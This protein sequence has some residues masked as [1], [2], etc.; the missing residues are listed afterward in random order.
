MKTHKFGPKRP[1]LSIFRLK[2]EKANF[3]FEISTL[4]F[5][6]LRNFKKKQKWLNWGPKM[7]YLGNFLVRT[8]K[9]Y[10]DIWNQHPRTC[11]TGKFRKKTKTRKF[12]TKNVLFTYFG[13]S[14]IKNYIWNQHP[15]ICQ[16][17]KFREKLKMP[18]FGT[19]N[20]FL[21][22]FLTG[23][24]K[25]YCDIWNQHSQISLVAKFWEKTKML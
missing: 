23:S 22:Y 5:V 16:I 20:A 12:R 9:I 3:I 14:I 17:T 11:Q 15:R 10:C 13:A 6:K 4:E 24:W 2:F 25:E 21:G 8:L 7:P 1:F 19:K 18:K